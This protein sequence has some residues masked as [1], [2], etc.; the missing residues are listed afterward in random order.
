MDTFNQFFEYGDILKAFLALFSGVI[1]GYERESKDKSAGLKTITLIS[2]GSALFTMLSQNFS[3]DGDSFAIAAGI[4]S[5]VGFLGAGVIYKQGFSIYGLTTA[6]IIWISSAI[7]MAIGFGEIYIALVFL[8]VTLL[9]IYGLQYLGNRFVPNNNNR[10]LSIEIKKELLKDRKKILHQLEQF[11]D[12]QT[13][14]K[15]EKKEN[16]NFCIDL[17]I[18]LKESKTE[19]LEDFLLANGSIETYSL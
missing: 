4:I 10:Y 9:I 1:L 18:Q 13:V 15:T 16:G 12:F 17:D 14:T 6:S 11:S 2:V 7:G 5:G 8:A 19:E 3:G